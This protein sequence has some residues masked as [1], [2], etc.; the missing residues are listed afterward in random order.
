M[1]P[2]W[3]C[4]P[5]CRA[6]VVSLQWRVGWRRCDALPGLGC[7]QQRA[8]APCFVTACGGPAPLRRCAL[9]C[10]L[11]APGTRTG[12]ASGAVRRLQG[13][14]AAGGQ[15]RPTRGMSQRASSSPPCVAWRPKGAGLRARG[16]VLPC[17]A[18]FGRRRRGRCGNDAPMLG[19]EHGGCCKQ[20]GAGASPDRGMLRGWRRA[21]SWRRP[22]AASVV[23]SSGGTLWRQRA[24]FKQ[25]HAGGGK[26]PTA[27]VPCYSPGR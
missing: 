19:K 23:R 13:L 17:R 11:A 10:R 6:L 3:C 8:D 22:C 20:C 16:R 12:K 25:P 5:A 26:V 27:A 24:C 9:R 18:R 15:V 2:L 21:G 7:S 1:R 14:C 4:K